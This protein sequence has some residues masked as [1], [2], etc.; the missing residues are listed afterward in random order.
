MSEEGRKAKLDRVGQP[1]DTVAHGFK[2]KGTIAIQ[3]K[4]KEGKLHS[5][6]IPVYVNN[7]TGIH[8]VPMSTILKT[9]LDV[10]A[11]SSKVLDEFKYPAI[12]YAMLENKYRQVS[13]TNTFQVLMSGP[14]LHEYI[15]SP[16]YISRKDEKQALYDALVNTFPAFAT[17][18]PTLQELQSMQL[19]NI[20]EQLEEQTEET[21]KVA[22]ENKDETPKVTEK[23]TTASKDDKP[24]DI[25]TQLHDM[26]AEKDFLIKEKSTQIENLMNLVE[27]QTKTI[28]EL[29]QA[30]P[31]FPPSGVELG[32]TWDMDIHSCASVYRGIETFW[33]NT[34]DN[35]FLDDVR[36]IV[37]TFVPNIG[38]VHNTNNQNT[39]YTNIYKLMGIKM[40]VDFFVVRDEYNKQEGKTYSMIEFAIHDKIHAAF[41]LLAAYEYAQMHGLLYFLYQAICKVYIM[42]LHIM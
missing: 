28:E 27:E 39:T 29:K 4:T 7:V 8:Y 38:A 40:G 11:D 18:L 23:E 25:L 3:G 19:S 35:R 12:M 33:N 15:D 1:E 21:P 14:A 17:P 6:N 9:Y 20:E 22:Q 16:N 42:C 10:K 5:V 31:I 37:T 36:G 30:Q 13:R 2:E 32:Q 34:S 26:M 41:L 24:K